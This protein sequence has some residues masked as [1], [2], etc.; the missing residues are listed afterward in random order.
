M[1]VSLYSIISNIL[2]EISLLEVQYYF[3]PLN[4]SVLSLC[5]FNDPGIFQSSCHSLCSVLHMSSEILKCKQ[6]KEE[7]EL[8][9]TK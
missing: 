7:S 6:G 8:L 9:G 2:K 3:L 4:F 5:P 1:P